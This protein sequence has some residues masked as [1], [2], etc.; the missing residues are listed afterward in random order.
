[1]QGNRAG[2]FQPIARYFKNT[3]RLLMQSADPDRFNEDV[4]SGYD[5]QIMMGNATSVHSIGEFL[6]QIIEIVSPFFKRD[7][8]GSPIT[9]GALNRSSGLASDC[10]VEAKPTQKKR[11][12]PQDAE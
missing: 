6:V 2:S 1:M 4:L 11:K 12:S 7:G 8:D 5:I 10:L 9:V 3:E